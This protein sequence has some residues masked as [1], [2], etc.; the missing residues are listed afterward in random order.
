MATWLSRPTAI[1]TL[2]DRRVKVCYF[3]IL[4]RGRTDTCLVFKNIWH[5]A[6]Q[7]P[8]A[9]KRYAEANFSI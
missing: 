2:I 3:M 5:Q 9:L 1:T 7:E 8:G 4:C 6:D